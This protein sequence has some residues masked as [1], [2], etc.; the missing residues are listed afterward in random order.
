VFGAVLLEQRRVMKRVVGEDTFRRGLEAVA[1]EQRSEYEAVSLLSW[2][3]ATT[4]TAVTRAVALEA[5]RMPEAF[6]RD[7]VV[8]GFGMV[9]RT[10]WR[11]LM[12]NSTD[13]ALIRRAGRL[14]S[15][16]VDKGVLKVLEHSPGLVVLD[17]LGWPEVDDLD[18]VALTAGV[19]AA[20]LSA[21]RTCVDVRAERTEHGARLTA[22][23][24]PAA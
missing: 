21:G 20:L 12:T 23:T 5:G 7:V 18:I 14:Y 22:R 11:I 17:V 19:E 3:R 15:K 13:E 9:L 24:T 8:A 1:A 16:T 10:L 2:C 6:M 4:A